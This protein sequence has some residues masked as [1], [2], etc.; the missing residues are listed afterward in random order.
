M[1][2]LL[3]SSSEVRELD[4]I[5]WYVHDGV[6]EKDKVSSE[7][8]RGVVTIPFERD[9]RLVAGNSG[10][11]EITGIQRVHVDDRVDVG[12]YDID[13]FYYDQ[14]KQSLVLTGNTPIEIIFSVSEEEFSISVFEE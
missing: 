7:G 1:R 5:N 8:V 9:V 10:V 14:T 3:A 12:W 4:Q 11:I 6:F 2:R 13:R